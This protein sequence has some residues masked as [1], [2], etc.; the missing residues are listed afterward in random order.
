LRINQLRNV[1]SGKEVEEFSAVAALV[2]GKHAIGVSSITDA[3]LLA[4]MTAVGPGDDHLRIVYVLC[5][6]RLHAGLER[7]PSLPIPARFV[8]TWTG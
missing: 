4:L 6:C 2:G 5:H 7:N 8:S 1:H 3:I